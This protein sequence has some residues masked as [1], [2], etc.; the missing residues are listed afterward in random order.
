[1]GRAPPAGAARAHRRRSTNR[2]ATPPGGWPPQGRARW[3]RAEPGGERR[4]PATPA[5]RVHRGPSSSLVPGDDEVGPDEPAFGAEEVAHQRRRDGEGRVG[6]HR[7]R[8]PREP[9]VGG[10]GPHHRHGL[11]GEPLGEEPRPHGV[12]LDGDDARAGLDEGPGQR[13]G[14][15]VDVDVTA[16]DARLGDEPAC[17]ASVELVEPPA[18]LPSPGHGAPGPCTSSRD[19]RLPTPPT[20]RA[21]IP[22]SSVPD[23]GTGS[24][25]GRPAG[26]AAAGPAQLRGHPGAAA[27]Q[28]V[29]THSGPSR[30]TP[31]QPRRASVRTRSA[32]S[33]S[34]RRP[35]PASPA[36]AR[37]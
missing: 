32:R 14:A 12:E 20:A 27:P 30:S 16:P 1:M 17:V 2:C 19:A 9:Q 4:A 31:G 5:G 7:V 18:G 28:V 15:D 29:S 35:T 10:V 22:P 23:R 11:A 34:R 13:P 24:R 21:T 26:P 36:T 37:A 8:A 25:A 3:R 6:D 33:R